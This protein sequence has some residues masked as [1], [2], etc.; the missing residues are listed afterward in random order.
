M[1]WSK[2]TYLRVKHVPDMETPVK[3]VTW[4]RSYSNSRET[5]GRRKGLEAL[6]TF[7]FFL[8]QMMEVS[9][10]ASGLNKSPKLL[11]EGDPR[12]R[13]MDFSWFV[14]QRL[15]FLLIWIFFEDFCFGHIQQLEMNLPSQ[16]NQVENQTKW[17]RQLCSETGWQAA[18]G[19]DSCDQ[20][21]KWDTPQLSFWK[22]FW[23][24]MQKWGLGCCLVTQ[25][26]LCDP[27]DYKSSRRPCPWDSSGRNTG[28]GCHSLLQ[29]SSWP[30]D[31][32]HVCIAG[33]FFTKVWT[34]VQGSPW[35]EATEMG[36]WE[37]WSIQNLW[38][39]EKE[40]AT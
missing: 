39:K 1:G 25:P 13:R 19:C 24:T 11:Q 2:G 6:S 37:R 20:G 35:G 22:T 8:S 21:N 36:V 16:Q 23:I 26:T 30:R 12:E 38:G 7:W 29:G 31:W 28:V 15:V 3:T 40:N 10:E 17:I 5:D 18:Q 4:Q 14:G 27:V 9:T 33:R 32:I 34:R